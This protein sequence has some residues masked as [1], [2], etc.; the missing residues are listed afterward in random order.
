MESPFRR[1]IA[2]PLT[3]AYGS[4]EDNL[5]DRQKPWIIIETNPAQL[6]LPGASGRIEYGFASSLVHW[7][8]A[9]AP[10][11]GDKTYDMFF[12]TYENFHQTPNRV[13][14]RCG[15]PADVTFTLQPIPADLDPAQPICVVR[16]ADGQFRYYYMPLADLGD[17]RFKAVAVDGRVIEGFRLNYD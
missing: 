9:V 8:D 6:E 3:P 14:I 1:G 10:R 12:A 15:L 2:Q 13:T 17:R 16:V 11:A 5:H 7:A 4:V